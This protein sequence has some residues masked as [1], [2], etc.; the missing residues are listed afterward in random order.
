VELVGKT[1]GHFRI[2]GEIGK[3]GMGVV[4]EAQ[5]LR[6]PRRVALKFLPDEVGSDDAALARFQQ[7][8]ESLS[9]LNHP[10]ICTIYEIGAYRRQ[11]FIAMERLEGETLGQRLERGP[12]P[13]TEIFDFGLQVADALAAAHTQNIVHRDVKPGNVFLTTQ[14]VIKLLDFGLATRRR[15]PEETTGP[16]EPSTGPMGHVSGT[17]GYVSPEQLRQHPID[18]R[19]DLFSLGA[20]LYRMTCGRS[21]FEAPTVLETINNV[22]HKDPPPVSAYR[23]DVPAGLDVCIA[24][25]LRKNP[26]ERYPSTHEVMEALRRLRDDVSGG[27]STMA[28]LAVLP[29]L[30]RGVAADQYFGEGL[31]DELITSLARLEGVRVTSRT[32]AFEFK[33]DDDVAEVGRRLGVRSVLHGTARW[34]GDRVRI[35]A[36]LVDVATGTHLW[37]EIYERNLRD[38]FDVQEDIAQRITTALQWRLQ[39]YAGRPLL[40]RYTDNP[41]IYNR[42][43]EARYWLHQQT[44]E[45]FARASDLFEAVLR[46]EPRFAPALAG[47]AHYYILIGFFGVRPPMEVWPEAKAKAQ[48]AIAMDPGLSAAHTSLALALTQYEWDFAGAER[49]H[50]EAIRLSPGDAQSRY[51]YSLHVLMMGRLPEALRE[52][53][54]ALELDPLSKQILSALAYIHYYAGNYDEALRQCRRTIAVDPTYFETYGCLGLT[55]LALGRKE[56]AIEAFDEADRLTGRVFPLA[57]A[58]LAYALGLAGRTTEAREVLAALDSARQQHYLPPTYL[59]IG[60]IGCGNVQAAFTALEEAY[61]VKDSTL[62]YLRILPVFR[63]LSRDPRYESLCRR[64]ALPVLSTEGLGTADVGTRTWP[65]SEMAIPSPP[66][67][68]DTAERKV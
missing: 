6:L 16:D 56:E 18:G 25:L 32:S 60:E 9:R 31:A 10:H 62:L 12:L 35:S 55:Q 59:A 68:S 64:L 20:L 22:L 38:I 14:G 33:G 52:M 47:L 36:R 1:V 5:D 66:Q 13:I 40:R 48:Q 37:S 53:T 26:R 51:F 42:Y 19:S 54:R 15:S 63:P 21:P 44:M 29:F 50:R 65:A 43:L 11:P 57:R 34:S 67:A 41:E 45:G 28:S 49:E 2:V 4:Y 8:A 58:F 27:R 39:R 3:G 17:P 46:E 61:A 30:S 23:P 7:E 24:T